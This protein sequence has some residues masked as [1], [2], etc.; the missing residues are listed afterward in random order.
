M[1]SA[2][3]AWPEG[4]T[5]TTAMPRQRHTQRTRSVSSG[6]VH[7]S[8]QYPSRTTTAATRKHCVTDTALVLVVSLTAMPVSYDHH[9]HTKTLC[10]RYAKQGHSV[11]SGCVP[12]CNTRLVRPPQ[13]HENTVSQT[14]HWFWLC[15]SLQYPSRT[16]TTATRKHCVTDTQSRDTVPPQFSYRSYLCA[17]KSPYALCTVPPRFPQSQQY[18]FFSSLSSSMATQRQL[19]LC[20]CHCNTCL[21]RPP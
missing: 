2:R 20:L 12:H 11:T 4:D 19:L 21:L 9:S 8:L 15:P 1:V 17:L 6:C 3:A 13:P 10:H 5:P 18:L 16:T 7:A 14:Q